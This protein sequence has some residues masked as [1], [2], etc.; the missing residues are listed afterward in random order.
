MRILLAEDN[1]RVTQFVVK[2]LQEAAP[3]DQV[4][5]HSVGMYAVI[6]LGES[7]IKIPRK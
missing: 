5:L 2:G 1:E 4:S 6:E 7:A 3:R